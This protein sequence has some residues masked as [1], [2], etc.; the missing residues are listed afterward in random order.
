LDTRKSDVN[1]GLETNGKT[2]N[3]EVR[4][5]LTAYIVMFATKAI[6]HSNRRKVLHVSKYAFPSTQNTIR[7][8]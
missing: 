4:A 3:M 8:F 7:K 1:K 6:F 5:T 2:K